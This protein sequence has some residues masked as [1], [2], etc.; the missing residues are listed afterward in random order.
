MSERVAI[1]LGT[2]ARYAKPG[3]LACPLV[4]IPLTEPSRTL[5]L[6]RELLRAA[7]DA[8]GPKAAW[9]DGNGS[10]HVEGPRA[11]YRITLHD[12][13]HD[14]GYSVRA[15]VHDWAERQRNHLT[16]TVKRTGLTFE[17]RQILKAQ[18]ANAK[19]KRQL[20]REFGGGLYS[21]KWN[22]GK[23]NYSRPNAPVSP[24][25]GKVR[26]VARESSYYLRAETLNWYR[27]RP[28]RRALG[29]VAA[30]YLA[31]GYGLGKQTTTWGHMNVPAA[32]YR[33]ADAILAPA[34][35]MRESQ[36]PKGRRGMGRTEYIKS[37]WRHAG[38][39]RRAH[40]PFQFDHSAKAMAEAHVKARAEWRVQCDHYDA[41]ETLIRQNEEWLEQLREDGKV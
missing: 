11:R 15:E 16:T 29:K 4:G 36:L 20:Q 41:L 10:L 5:I 34:K 7:L 14:A 26:E 18:E 22:G 9:C 40:N 24:F 2:L 33:A 37:L 1:P 6:R 21:M 28:Q 17:Q 19:L 23:F 25:L 27:Q 31:G 3:R 35:L 30:C 39:A 38:L 13:A 8:P 12:T 32:M